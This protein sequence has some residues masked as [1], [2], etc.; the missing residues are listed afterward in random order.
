VAQAGFVLLIIAGL[1]VLMV[2]HELGHHLVARAFGL[3]VIRFSI[4]FGPAL[5]RY[6]PRGSETVYQ[7]ALIPFLAYVQVAGMN[8]FEE[9]DPDDKGSYANAPLTARVATVAAGPFANYLF[10]SV[11]VFA[12]LLA[13]GQPEASTRVT[14]DE[15]S[16]AA[17]GQMESGDKIV[18]VDDTQI[19]TFEV[20]QTVI[21]KNAGNQLTVQVLRQGRHVDLHVT[22]MTRENGD[23]LIGVRPVT[24]YAPVAIGEA[25][26]AAIV[27]PAEVVKRLLVDL[28]RM[29]SRQGETP[30]VTGPVG[31]VKIGARI[32]ERGALEFFFF[33][34]TL[35]AYLGGFNL[36][37]VPA[38][39]GGRLMFLGYEAVARRKPNAKVEAHIHALGLLMFLALI[40]VVTVRDFQRPSE[41][42]GQPQKAK[43]EQPAAAPSNSASE[44]P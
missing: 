9:N 20:L 34:A 2:V 32:A 23:G 28:G 16:P 22:P 1:A 4:G 25:T 39:D 6:Q 33:M 15:G 42:D 7:V 11:L 31:I 18:R 26:K 5:W 8:P 14:V 12:A 43:T 36:L 3:R 19:E 10:G 24:V 30:D 27:F 44:R 13:F 21:Q 41:D 40:A 29:I 35:S 17:Q 38:L 37:P